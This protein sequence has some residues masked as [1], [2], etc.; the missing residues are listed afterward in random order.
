MPYRRCG[1]AGEF[2]WADD[3]VV[4]VVGVERLG[5]ELRTIVKSSLYGTLDDCKASLDLLAKVRFS[6]AII[7]H[8]PS[9]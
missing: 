5:A 6:Y 1:F 8:F 4:V 9:N 3:F 2:A 7:D